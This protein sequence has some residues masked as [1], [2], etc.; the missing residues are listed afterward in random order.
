MEYIDNYWKISRHLRQCYWDEPALTDAVAII[1]F[2]VM[3]I[4]VLLL[5][6]N[7]K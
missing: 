3:I 6:L 7:K 2:M 1:F 5:N 4:T